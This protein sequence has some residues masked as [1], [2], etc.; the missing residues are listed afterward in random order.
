MSNFLVALYLQSLL[1]HWVE[2]VL[3]YNK[4]LDWDW[5]CMW[6]FSMKLEHDHVGDQLQLSNLNF[7]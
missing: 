1:E 3:I 5:F 2:I 4:M 7:L 6:L